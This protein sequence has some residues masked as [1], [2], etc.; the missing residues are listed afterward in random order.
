MSITNFIPK[1]LYRKNGQEYFLNPDGKVVSH[2]VDTTINYRAAEL[3]PLV[4]IELDK[5]RAL[6]NYPK[7][8]TIDY[9]I[10]CQGESLN[11]AINYIG[12]RLLGTKSY[13]E[14][15]SKGAENNRKEEKHRAETAEL[16]TTIEEMRAQQDTMQ[17][18]MINIANQL[19]SEQK[20]N[21]KS[22]I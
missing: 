19:N 7:E 18:L 12:Y 1:I 8:S 6:Y 13:L 10:E 5:A 17:R 3:D 4:K 14:V 16:K 21:F 9:V 20:N 22:V 11:K 2:S 15:F